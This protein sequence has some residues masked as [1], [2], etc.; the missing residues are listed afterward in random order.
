MHKRPTNYNPNDDRT[1]RYV[2]LLL[3]TPYALLILATPFVPG[4]REALAILG[5]F[6]GYAVRYL[7]ET[8]RGDTDEE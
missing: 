6:V 3:V 7:F 5:P 8:R 1:R 2:A 4:T